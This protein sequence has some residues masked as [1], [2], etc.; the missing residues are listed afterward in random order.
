MTAKSIFELD[1]VRIAKWHRRSSLY[2][3]VLILSWIL[4]ILMSVNSIN[5][6]PSVNIGILIFFWCTMPVS[7][8]LVIAMQR[9]LGS[10]VLT[11]IIYGILAFF[12]SLLVFQ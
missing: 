4:L 10:N 7:I 3:F 11:C 1:L 9:S 8:A 12:L 5:L 2:A 6:P